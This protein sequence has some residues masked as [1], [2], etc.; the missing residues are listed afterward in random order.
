MVQILPWVRERLD[1]L[2]RTNT[3]PVSWQ[4][5]QLLV[6]MTAFAVFIGVISLFK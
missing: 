5:Y 4:E 3:E 6:A 2:R 1:D